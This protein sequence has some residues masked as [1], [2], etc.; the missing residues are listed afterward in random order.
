[1]LQ[2]HTCILVIKMLF[3]LKMCILV[4]FML[5]PLGARR[6]N[7]QPQSPRMMRLQDT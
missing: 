5:L 6:E 4:L 7:S 2:G 1:M 3:K